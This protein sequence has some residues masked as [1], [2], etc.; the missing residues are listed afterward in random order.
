MTRHSILLAAASGFALIAATGAHA[1]SAP[2]GE[3][4]QV[5]EIVVTG[6]RKSLRDALAVKQ[7][8]DKV[9]EAIS[10]KDIGVLP[11]VTIAESIARLPGVNATRDR[12]NDSQAVVRGLGARL[13]LGT[14]N[15]REVAS[16][17]PDR[18]VRWEIYPSEVV[19]GV[20]VYKSQ[21]ADLIAGGVA[22]S[23]NIDTIAPLDYKGPSF[24][25]RA[26]PV[27]YDGGEDIPNYDRTGYRA[28]GSFVHKFSDDL[29]I[30]LG[31]TSQQQKNGYP[32][33]T[34]WGYNDHLARPPAGA[35]D[36]SGDLNGDG[37]L[38][39]TPWGAQLS[40]SRIDQKRSGVSTGLQWKPSDRF[41]LKGDMLYSK[42]KID[43]RQDQTVWGRNNWGNWNNGNWGDYHATGASF[44]VLNGSVVAATIPWSSVTT[45][46]SHYTEDKELLVGGL[47]GKWTADQWVVTGDVSYSKAERSNTWKAV[48]VEAYPSSTSFDTRAGKTPTITTSQA[49]SGLAQFAN[50]WGSNDGP[51]HLNDEL[52][53]AAFDVGRDLGEGA[54]KSVKFGGRIS[55]RTKDHNRFSFSTAPTGATVPGN[56]FTSYK[57]SSVNVPAVLTGDFDKIA[58]IAY[59]ANAFKP[60]NASEE[61]AQRWSVNEK[62]AEGY[63]MANFATDGVAGS[64]MTGNFGVRVVHTKTSS[65]GYRQ[66][67]GSSPLAAVTVEHDYTDVLP[68]ANVKFDFDE[69]RIVRL[70]LAQVVARPPLDELR[71]SRTLTSWAPYTGSAGNPKLDPFKA[72]QFDAS[73]EWY[74]RPEALLAASYYYKNVDS[75]IGWK[76]SPVTYAGTTYAVSSPTNGGSGYIQGVELAFQTPFFFAPGI[77]SKFGIYSNYAYVDS[78]LK[79]FSPANNPL[80]MTGLAKHTATVDLW[81]ADGPVEARLGYKYHS[82]MTVIYGWSGADLQTLESEKTLDFSS[83]WQINKTLG[84]R[85]QVNNLTNEALRMYRDNKPDRI[86]RYDVYGRRYLMDVTVKF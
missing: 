63:A 11:D 41:E 24:V 48:R 1:Q 4:A 73:A 35:S 27:Y 31:L 56:L 72:L 57:V 18:N 39:A 16:T 38:D 81:Y 21:S 6:V 64:W 62:V 8:S 15:S 47:N 22:A 2:A 51:E 19:S 84:L 77:L 66:A 78:D 3:A 43:E 79:E 26:G 75:Y 59:G 44:T 80:D 82:P 30:V 45:V 36:Y 32:S 58:A 12:G 25:G 60:S 28:S 53:A 68:S 17:E 76:Q 55:D 86:G 9:V 85:F 14:V 46:L 61:L 74:F 50:Q 37:K 42:I 34:G 10:A 13:V 65:D 49:S 7:G 71:A 54:L 67:T 20:Q 40:V 70:G 33:F 29:A 69:G 23:I 52:K 83:S 5:E